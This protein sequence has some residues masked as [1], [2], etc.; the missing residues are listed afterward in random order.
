MVKRCIMVVSLSNN[1]LL[2]YVAGSAAAIIPEIMALCF[3]Q[4]SNKLIR[5]KF[6]TSAI[7]R[8][9]EKLPLCLAIN[10]PLHPLEER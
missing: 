6:P 3:L 9:T 1:R 8:S 5:L 4:R 7:I 10:G 2:H